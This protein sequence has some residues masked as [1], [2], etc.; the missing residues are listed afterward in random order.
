[1]AQAAAVRLYI[2]GLP[3]D[4]SCEDV[5]ARFS[6]FG[7]VEQ[8]QLAPQKQPSMYSAQGCRWDKRLR[9]L[10]PSNWQPLCVTR[11]PAEMSSS[12]ALSAHRLPR[13][14]A[15][16][17]QGMQTH[18]AAGYGKFAAQGPHTLAASGAQRTR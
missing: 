18:A 14:L 4:I 2:G 9:A 5:A 1:M 11:P 7:S 8:L 3:E 10:P 17:C 13:P 16:P 6:P 15:H 12:H